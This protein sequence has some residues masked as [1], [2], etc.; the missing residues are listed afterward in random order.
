MFIIDYELV[1]IDKNSSTDLNTDWY[2][3]TYV[4]LEGRDKA[5]LYIVDTR[6]STVVYF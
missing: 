4:F 3:S 2:V 5:K 1:D 6:A